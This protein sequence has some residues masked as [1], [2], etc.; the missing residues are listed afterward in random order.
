MSAIHRARQRLRSLDATFTQ[1]RNLSLL[2]TTVTSK[3]RLR[4]SGAALRWDIDAP[5]EITYWIGKGLVSYRSPSSKGQ[6]VT[7][8]AGATG[9]VMDDLLVAL[10]GDLRQLSS[11]HQVVCEQ[12]DGLV[13]IR[14]RPA[15]S[16]SHSAF[17]QIQ[18][19][20]ASDLISPRQILIEESESDRIR[21]QFD[22]L[23]IN[24]PIDATQ[25]SPPA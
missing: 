3:G 21:I 15:D 16:S 8:N 4:F 19:S 18:L 11:R 12:R 10:T 17:R 1:E 14:V 24:V 5:D 23:R 13:H 2:D 9:L 7:R 22:S 20:V 6:V 25:L